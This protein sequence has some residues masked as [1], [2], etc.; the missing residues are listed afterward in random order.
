M[1]SMASYLQ[2]TP[3]DTIRLLFF[4]LE[5]ALSTE[6]ELGTPSVSLADTVGEWAAVLLDKEYIDSE[7]YGTSMTFVVDVWKQ[8]ELI[9]NN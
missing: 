2:I 8:F 3:R 5:H 6:I 9:P 4:E 7:E 1:E